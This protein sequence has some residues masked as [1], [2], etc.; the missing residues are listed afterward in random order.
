MRHDGSGHAQDFDMEADLK[1]M[2]STVWTLRYNVVKQVPLAR[3]CPC[4]SHRPSSPH[5]CLLPQIQTWVML[6]IGIVLFARTNELTTNCPLYEDMEL[7][8]PDARQQWD[9]DGLPKYIILALRC[10]RTCYHS[11]PPPLH[12]SPSMFGHQEMEDSPS[13]TLL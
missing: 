10:A 3:L 11:S 1:K 13:S 2:W 6:L 9:C 4:H 7:P 8:P 12:S 5:P